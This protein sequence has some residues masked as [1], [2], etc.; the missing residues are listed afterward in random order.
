VFAKHRIAPSRIINIDEKGFLIGRMPRTKRILS[1]QLYQK[2]QVRG[3]KQDGSREWISF[4]AAIVADGRALSPAIIFS[5]DSGYIRDAWIEDYC[6]NSSIRALFASTESGWINSDLALDWLEKIVEPETRAEGG[7]FRLL[8]LDGHAT[9][10][11]TNLIEFCAANRIILGLLPPHSTHKLQPLDVGIFGP[12]A[13]AY[14]AALESKLSSLPLAGSISKGDFWQ[15]FEAAWLKAANPTNVVSSFESTGIHPYQPM[16]TLG[17]LPSQIEPVKL[18]SKASLNSKS[19]AVRQDLR[20]AGLYQ[21][22]VIQELLAVVDQATITEEVSK[23]LAS[24]LEAELVR[25]KKKK[26]RSRPLLVPGLPESGKGIFL[27]PG[28]IALARETLNTEQAR[29]EAE[30]QEKEDLKIQKQLA[31]AHKREADQLK[32]EERAAAAAGRK[33]EKEKEAAERAERVA[34]RKA[35]AASQKEQKEAAKQARLDRKKASSSKE[36]SYEAPIDLAEALLLLEI[37]DQ[38][39][40]SPAITTKIGRNIRRPTRFKD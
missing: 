7:K 12:L 37:E 2:K 18:E 15:I 17:R 36:G 33:V 40:P 20:K 35:L 8:L 19:R 16:K 9:H 10:V 24:Q 28:K 29:K 31:A 39:M 38:S 13:S 4:L 3:V 23:H 32:R 30:A 26:P 1:R 25:N 27:S 5:G 34:A 11:T 22:P 6:P 14:S 21:L